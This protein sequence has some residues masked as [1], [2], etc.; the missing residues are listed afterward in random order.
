MQAVQVDVKGQLIDSVATKVQLVVELL[1]KDP[2]DGLALEFFLEELE[3]EY[4]HDLNEANVPLVT[5][6]IALP[7][8]PHYCPQSDAARQAIDHS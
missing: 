7:S 4:E 8:R 5:P 2:R 3:H 1:A 6:D